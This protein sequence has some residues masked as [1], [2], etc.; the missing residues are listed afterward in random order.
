MAAPVALAFRIGAN[1]DALRTNLAEANAQL[2]TTRSAMT[3][4]SNS[5]DGSSLIANANAMVKVVND[6]GGASNLTATEQAKVNATVEEALAKYQALGQVAPPGMQA[7]ADATKQAGA[8][9][10]QFGDLVERL[11]ERFA[12]YEVLRGALDF[13][14][15]ILTTAAAMEDL[16]LATGINTDDLQKLSYVGVEFGVQTDMMARGV[17]QLSAKLANGDKNATAAVQEL[18]LSVSDL[19]SKGPEE[20]FLSIADAAGRVEDPMT[21]G[22]LAAQLFG[23]RLGKTLL[24]MLS[25][26]RQKMND[27]PKDAIISE[28]TIKSAHDFEVGL[29]H[30]ETRLKSWT[31]TAIESVHNGWTVIGDA[32]TNQRTLLPDEA[33]MVDKVTDSLKAQTVAAGPVITNAQQLRNRLTAL[34]TEAVAPLDASQKQNILTLHTYGESLVDIAKLVGSNTVAVKLFLDA[35]KAAEEQAKKSAEAMK[36]LATEVDNLAS[37]MKVTSGVS[38]AFLDELDGLSK[39]ARADLDIITGAK[40]QGQVTALQEAFSHLYQ[41]GMQPTEAELQKTADMAGELFK[42]GADLTPQ[43][44]I[45]AATFGTLTPKVED[46]V[47]KVAELGEKVKIVIPQVPK[48]KDGLLELGHALDTLG[49]AVS[50]FDPWLG[51]LITDF[52]HMATSIDAAGKAFSAA[53]K[54]FSAGDITK[55]ILGVASGISGIVTAAVAAGNAISSLWNHFFGSAGRDAV[56]AFAN[57]FGGFDQLH[58]QLDAI[59]AA[60]EQMWIKL[61]Q[62][63]G[64][65]D[66]A[67]AQATIAQIN[68][69]LKGQTDY[70]SRLPQEMQQYGLTWEQ[71][72]A[73]AEQSHLDSIGANLVQTFADLTKAGFNVDMVTQKMSTDINAYIDEAIRTGTE[74]P[75]A[76]KPLLQHMIDLGT[77][78]DNAGNA[79]TDLNSSGITFSDTL[80]QGFQSVVDA[81]NQLTAAL[82][83]VPG[84]IQKIPREVNVDVNYSS[85]GAPGGDGSAPAAATG[86]MVGWGN[87]IPFP[88]YMKDGGF[89]GGPRGTDTVPVWATPGEMI[90]NKAQQAALFGGHGDVHVYIDGKEMTA[91]II[92]GVRRDAATGRLRTRAGAGRTY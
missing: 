10:S 74:V 15:E 71:A 86:G 84:A 12:I 14:K 6:L 81:I 21:K 29:E 30:L 1:L 83:A 51:K 32:L 88:S 47:T 62:Q 9:T 40:S 19:L 42:K 55:G 8:E 69:L 11:T 18:G 90:L 20:A 60:G 63:T 73:S 79:I 7:L 39:A 3:R 54:A 77:L 76:M 59:G 13:S 68:A 34:H 75:A 4:M 25:E 57:T 70:L 35:H 28:A 22:G 82:G 26:L 92:R 66:L 33:A 50:Q 80:T 87:V 31:V 56:V 44:T 37:R 61:T 58:A 53:G 17:E 23:G 38:Q 64:R 85:H 49:S 67:G 78:T 52:G 72:G 36:K 46:G 91:Q 89:P 24:P 27:V 16:S 5:L 2:E 48:L 65:N 43:L 45:L 41:F